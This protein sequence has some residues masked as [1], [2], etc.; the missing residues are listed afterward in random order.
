MARVAVPA[1]LVTCP[2]GVG[3]AHPCREAWGQE[4]PSVI[5]IRSSKPFMACTSRV[6]IGADC[7]IS[8]STIGW[9][10]ANRFDGN[11][12]KLGVS[13]VIYRQPI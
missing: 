5:A 4:M 8:E 7:M 1:A 10:I 12:E 11:A 6:A 13:E 3:L 9:N 2:W